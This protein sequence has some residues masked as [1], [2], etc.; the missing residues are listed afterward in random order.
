MIPSFS[1]AWKLFIPTDQGFVLP[2][3]TLTCTAVNTAAFN[4]GTP[5]CEV[6]VDD[7][8]AYGAA[9]SDTSVQYSVITVSNL[10]AG[11][12]F[13]YELTFD[14]TNPPTAKVVNP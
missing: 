14:V 1:A 6:T 10:A 13:R 11:N 3:G 4:G 9:D 5:S 12:L 2:A 7:A 8:Q